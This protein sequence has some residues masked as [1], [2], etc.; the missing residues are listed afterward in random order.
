[1]RH[2]LV[3]FCCLFLVVGCAKTL[4]A[5][6]IIVS[7]DEG[8]L[9]QCIKVSA[10]SAS[11]SSVSSQPNAIARDGQSEVIVGLSETADLTGTISVIV[12]RFKNERCE[13]T[14]TDSTTKMITLVRGETLELA[15]DYRSSPDAG[16]DAGI[17]AGCDLSMCPARG[18][19]DGPMTACCVYAALDAGSAC[20][21]AGAC[22]AQ[23][24][25]VPECQVLPTGTSCT[26][27]LSCLTNKICNSSLCTGSCAGTAPTCQQLAANAC[28]PDGV[29]CQQLPNLTLNDTVCGEQSQCRVG[30]CLK[31]IN[32][33]RPETL[34]TRLTDLPEY[35][36]GGW[37]IGVTASCT[38]D[39]DTDDDAGTK[40]EC[41]TVPITSLIDD[42]GVRVFVV[43][44]LEVGA[45]GRLNFYGSRPAQ[46]IV[47]GDATITGVVG[48]VP[49]PIHVPAGANQPTWCSDGGA[50]ADGTVATQ[51]AG[52]GALGDL[53][54][55]GGNAG[56][57]G[58]VPVSSLQLASSRLRGGCS[59]GTGM[60]GNFGGTGGG[61]L[62]L[63]V[64]DTL[65][66]IDGGVVS[67]SGGG[68]LGAQ[69]PGQGAGA[70]G[71][72]GMLQ[73]V[74]RSLDLERGAVTANGGNGGA[75]GIS[76]S[77]TN[78]GLPGRI[79]SASA[80]DA[81]VT[82]NGGTGGVGGVSTS[83]AG[84]AGGDSDAG[85][86]APGG[87]G[88]GSIG[89]LIIRGIDR[90]HTGTGVVSGA[91]AGIPQPCDD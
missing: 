18:P 20:G 52:G 26:G 74:A 37:T 61:G 34:R 48:A 30:S 43:N 33:A 68:G 47:L 44:S 81:S 12:R 53:G 31:W 78:D 22:N 67:V 82:Q 9:T 63:I 17:D 49:S 87:G 41:A 57:A 62:S 10:T 77:V 32:F 75:G 86:L 14:E 90:C 36:D 64:S 66:V 28:T 83:P 27:G 79:D 13:G 73:L 65:R 70:G 60:G 1:M 6:K 50:G 85:A 5:V 88:G 21:D 89:L 51:G 69:S 59:G 55:P 8:D 91:T 35:P 71:S 25:C 15:F 23:R 16:V 45:F 40:S 46:L 29:S 38:V 56:G 7:L 19:C 72:G 84:S 54:G 11:G 42:A 3:G 39:I 80:P 58:G 4:G 2:W 76:P 24:S